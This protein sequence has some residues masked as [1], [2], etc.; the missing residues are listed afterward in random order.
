MVAVGTALAGGPPHRSK[1]AGLRH[2]APASGTNVE[3]HTGPG[4]HDA[5]AR[6]PSFSKPVHALPVEA[7]ALAAAPQR[8]VPVP[9]DLVPE[10][11][12]RFDV[13]GHGVVNEVPS[14]HAR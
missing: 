4:M 5:G 12:H 9:D 10:G 8:P 11:L 2:W 13:A 3:A 14:H 7:M 6:K 1:R